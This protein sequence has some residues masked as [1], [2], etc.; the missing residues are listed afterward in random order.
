MAAGG[1]VDHH[2]IERAAARRHR[3]GEFERVGRVAGTGRDRAPGQQVLIDDLACD[4]L[5][6]DDENAG[7]AQQVDRIALVFEHARERHGEPKRRA[8][9]DAAVEADLA[10]HQLDD[11]ARDRKAESRA[12]VAPPR[13][14]IGLPERFEELVGDLGR[15]ARPGVGH[16]EPQHR[17]GAFETFDDRTYGD[18]AGGGELHRVAEQVEQNLTQPVGVADHAPRHV[19]RDVGRQRKAL[20]ARRR[21]G[22]LAARLG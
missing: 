9:P 12:A 7:A 22:G 21:R 20:L 18:A 11:P 14:L 19:L 17:I 16:R 4:G 15:D 3:A 13:R 6:V 2:R 10:A 8:A 1:A 5:F